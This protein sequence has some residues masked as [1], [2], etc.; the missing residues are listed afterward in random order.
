[1]YPFTCVY[2]GIYFKNDC[3]IEHIKINDAL[4]YY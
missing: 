2:F 4:K 3:N 1:M